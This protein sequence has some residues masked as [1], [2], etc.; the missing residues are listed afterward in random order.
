VKSPHFVAILVSNKLKPKE[1]NKVV[2]EYSCGEE[3]GRL[4]QLIALETDK[5]IQR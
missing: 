2:V 4:R 5:K 3:V 1:T